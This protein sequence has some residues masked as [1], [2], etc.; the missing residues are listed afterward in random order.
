[1]YVYGEKWL[2]IKRPQVY[3]R[4]AN[5]PNSEFSQNLTLNCNET[6]LA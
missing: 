3:Q 4:K 5:H 2:E 6:T 1:M